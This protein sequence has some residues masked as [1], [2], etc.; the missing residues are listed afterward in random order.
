MAQITLTV[1]IRTKLLKQREQVGIWRSERQS[2]SEQICST[3][4][5]SLKGGRLMSDP[6]KP[7]PKKEDRE[8]QPDQHPEVPDNP[9]PLGPPP[10]P[11]PKPDP[12][13][14]P[15]DLPGG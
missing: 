12:T 6:K 1:L 3:V 14:K 5:S 9:V 11:R 10:S 4:S 8:G 7:V 15:P 2:S 13:P